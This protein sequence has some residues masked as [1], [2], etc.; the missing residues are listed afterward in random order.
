MRRPLVSAFVVVALTL[1][2]GASGAPKVD[3]APVVP[4]TGEQRVLVVLATWG[5][6]PFSPA[7]V[8]R[9]LEQSDLFLRGSSYGKVSLRATV[10]PWLAIPDYSATCTYDPVRRA[11]RPAV[12]G[13]GYDPSA[14]DGVL[15]LYPRVP[16]NWMGL[17]LGKEVW[18]NGALSRDLVVHEL[19][20]TF[21]LGHA[22][23]GSCVRSY[24]VALEYGD[25]YDTM[26]QG[27]GDFSAFAKLQLGWLSHVTEPRQPGVLLLDALEAASA[28]PQALVVT[29]ARNQ[30]WLESRREAAR[31]AEGRI[32]SP[33]G[34]LVHMGP[35]PTKLLT[36]QSSYLRN[37][38]VVDPAGHGRT[39]LLAGDRFEEPG[40][41]TATV[42]R[43]QAG[44]ARI[45]F[46]WTDRTPPAVPRIVGI[47]Q[48]VSLGVE[49][50][51]PRDT[52]SGLERYEISLD[53]R[54][55]SAAETSNAATFGLPRP[56]RHTLRLVA[57][58]RAGNRSAPATRSFTVSG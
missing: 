36:G 39:A 52:G 5:P 41:F 11:S 33:A 22:N 58:D 49:W 4:I 31:D 35:N 10:T 55:R 12:L 38:L 48:T 18:L 43:P 20:H 46:R 9:V 57:I 56:G 19:G 7:E 15:Y 37:M 25:P 45:G 53:G 26:G 40:S 47:A 30:Y 28:R 6:E 3:G 16:C 29:T 23:T 42:L 1:A 34:V 21:G 44:A 24:C 51:T 17:T 2:P 54:A 50:S 27:S 8:R 14:F 32:V 13:L